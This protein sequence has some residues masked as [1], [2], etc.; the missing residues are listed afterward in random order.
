[1]RKI[2]CWLLCLW[3]L[4]PFVLMT[5]VYPFFRFGMFA[6]PL[7][8]QQKTE[9]LQLWWKNAEGTPFLFQPAVIG[10]SENH[11]GYV[12]RHYFYTNKSNSSKHQKKIKTKSCYLA[13]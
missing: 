11:W 8:P 10:L 13:N 4:V 6:E 2:I 12:L 3:F 5:D 9:M 1:M 7:K